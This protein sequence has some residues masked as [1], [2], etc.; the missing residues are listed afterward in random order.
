[1]PGYLKTAPQLLEVRAYISQEIEKYIKCHSIEAGASEV[2]VG[3][4]PSRRLDVE[5]RTGDSHC[6]PNDSHTYC[7]ETFRGSHTS[8]R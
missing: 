8:N 2:G 1:M 4:E 5:A 7:V 3:K 6:Y